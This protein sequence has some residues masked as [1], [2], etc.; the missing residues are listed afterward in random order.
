[1]GI[2]V[3][4]IRLAQIHTTCIKS[5]N[6]CGPLICITSRVLSLSIDNK[7]RSNFDSFFSNVILPISLS[8]LSPLS[9]VLYICSTNLILYS[10]GIVRSQTFY[11]ALN[12][13]R[14]FPIRVLV[15][16]QRQDVEEHQIVKLR[17]YFC[18]RRS[19]LYVICI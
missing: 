10:T 1:M 4:E 11:I 3:L 13:I 8:Y 16:I 6:T 5:N 18:M 15:H 9:I 2:L 7:V 12:R 14:E 19:L 17:F